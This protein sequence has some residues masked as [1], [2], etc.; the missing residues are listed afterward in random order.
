MLK[1]K[2]FEQMEVQATVKK[3]A[4]DVLPPVFFKWPPSSFGGI[5]LY[6]RQKLYYT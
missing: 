3:T 2:Q 4:A 1:F 6:Y 5:L